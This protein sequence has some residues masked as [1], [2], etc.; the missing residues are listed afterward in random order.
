MIKLV[1][2]GT[3]L[4]NVWLYLNVVITLTLVFELTQFRFHY[5]SF[6]SLI[7]ISE[8]LLVAWPEAEHT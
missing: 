7:F 8:H 4:L 5:G 3:S 2:S 6:D 1:Q